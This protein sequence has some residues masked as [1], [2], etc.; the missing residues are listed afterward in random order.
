MPPARLARAIAETTADDAR[1]LHGAIGLGD[2][3]VAAGSAGF[4]HHPFMANAL[5]AMMGVGGA[6]R[7]SLDLADGLVAVHDRE[8]DVHEDEIGPLRACACHAD[9]PLPRRRRTPIH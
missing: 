8:L 9:R 6:V 4:P 2:V 5:T 1:K 3:V 7:V